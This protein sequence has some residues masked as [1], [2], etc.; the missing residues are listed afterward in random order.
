MTWSILVRDE[1]GNFGMAIASRFFAVGSLCLHSRRGIGM[2]S[3]QALMNPL[4][5]PAGL[6][7][8]SQGHDAASIIHQLTAH[9][10]GRDQR[11][12]H[13]LPASGSAIAHTGAA[14]VD[15]CGHI[16]L[17]GVSVAGN[18]H[19]CSGVQF[20]RRWIERCTRSAQQ[21]NMRRRRHSI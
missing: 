4:Y 2:L 17:D 18:F 1:Q 16:S 12:I 21:M 14:C 7:L 19:S 6:N 20:A 11:Q 13:I 9:D 10:E 5:G 8:L 3:T 15:W